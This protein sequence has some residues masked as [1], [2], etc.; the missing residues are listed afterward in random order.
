MKAKEI[1]ITALAI[2]CITIT[3]LTSCSKNIFNAENDYSIIRSF[4]DIPGVSKDEITAI[5][6]LQKK[7]GSLV[8]GM[9]LSSEGF[10]NEYGEVDGYA[11]FFM[12]MADKSFWH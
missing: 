12:R 2:L 7:R 1:K 3:G 10:F 4:R 11:A 8:Y 9:T 6:E 5:E